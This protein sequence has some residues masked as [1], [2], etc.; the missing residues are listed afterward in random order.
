M[1]SSAGD[2]ALKGVA[3]VL[4]SSLYKNEKGISG[5]L[6]RNERIDLPRMIYPVNYLSAAQLD[7]VVGAVSLR[8]F[9]G[10]RM[11]QDGLAQ[12]GDA[13]YRMDVGAED[14]TDANNAFGEAGFLISWS[15]PGR[16]SA[17]CRER[18][19]F[20]TARLPNPARP[21]IDRP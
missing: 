6:L 4:A 1:A 9:I 3:Y 10:Q 12:V 19:P 5:Y 16:R 7:H 17:G 21:C 11:G 14:L 18:R 13:L 15:K 8:A 2:N 20:F